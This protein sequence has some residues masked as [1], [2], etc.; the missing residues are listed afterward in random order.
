MD[1]QHVD[2]ER[3]KD[4]A[5]DRLGQPELENPF[6]VGAVGVGGH[7]GDRRLASVLALLWPGCGEDAWGRGEVEP[8]V[9]RDTGLVV[10]RRPRPSKITCRSVGFVR[11]TSR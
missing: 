8:V 3:R 1:L 7:G 5:L 9:D 6:A 2:L 10:D 11:F 4:S